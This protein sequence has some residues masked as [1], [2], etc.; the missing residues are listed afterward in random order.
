MVWRVVGGTAAPALP[1]QLCSVAVGLPWQKR[2]PILHSAGFARNPIGSLA[3]WFGPANRK[4][5]GAAGGRSPT[6]TIRVVREGLAQV[7]RTAVA[8]APGLRGSSRARAALRRARTWEEQADAR[9]SRGRRRW[10]ASPPPPTQT[11]GPPSQQPLCLPSAL[12]AGPQPRFA[13]HC[14]NL[15][16][17]RRFSRSV[18]Q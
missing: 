16:G 18:V 2:P 15:R 17:P 7:L 4:G 12:R 9:A 6:G 14:Q 1:G 5:L 11:S 13:C 3:G 10:W 8:A